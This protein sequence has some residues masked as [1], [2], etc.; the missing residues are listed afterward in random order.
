MQMH[1][2]NLFI[3]RSQKLNFQKGVDKR[4]KIW[5]FALR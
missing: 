2:L 1:P 3:E 4:P 5:G